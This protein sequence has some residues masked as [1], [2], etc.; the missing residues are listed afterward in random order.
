[1]IVPL[2]KV[3]QHQPTLHPIN[4][5]PFGQISHLMVLNIPVERWRTTTLTKMFLVIEA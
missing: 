1:M 2:I 4:I 5:R 3:E